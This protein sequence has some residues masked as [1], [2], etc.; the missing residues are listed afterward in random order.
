MVDIL[1][2]KSESHQNWINPLKTFN[3]QS[4][5]QTRVNH[6]LGKEVPIAMNIRNWD[7]L[8][9]YLFNF[10][11]NNITEKLR[12][13]EEYKVEDTEHSLYLQI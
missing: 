7:S 13:E 11:I 9:P 3:S 10:I 2:E 4:R 6:Q 8:N 12:K 5:T 1:E